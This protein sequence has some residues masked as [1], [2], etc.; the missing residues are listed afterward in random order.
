MIVFF[1]TVIR[2]FLLLQ[3]HIANIETN[4]VSFVFLFFFVGLTCT[5]ALQHETYFCFPCS[6]P[7]RC[8]FVTSV[9]Q[10][11]RAGGD[12]LPPGSLS[13][14]PATNNHMEK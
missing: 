10:S 3:Q 14:D 6:A 9:S 1:N 13:T 8:G 11:G 12:F 5:V 7:T 2:F 4:E